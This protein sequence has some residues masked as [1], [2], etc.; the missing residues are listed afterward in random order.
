MPKLVDAEIRRR[1]IAEAVFRVI[2]RDGLAQTSLRGVAEEAGLA[3]GS[4]RHY[5]DNHDEL[6]VFA[7]RVQVERLFI[8]LATHAEQLLD[9]AGPKD[10]KTRVALTEQLLGELL[11][12]DAERLAEAEVWLA[13]SAA[14]RLRPELAAEATKVHTGTR[15]LVRRVLTEAAR[16]GNLIKKLDI[17]LETERLASLLDGLAMAA[18]YQPEQTTPELMRRVLRR[19]LEALRR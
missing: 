11:P 4:V 12:L 15:A 3:L 16:G 2:R 5:F 7:M 19:H 10:R 13:F 17:E 8:R 1:E 14:A 6:I 18:T 9:P